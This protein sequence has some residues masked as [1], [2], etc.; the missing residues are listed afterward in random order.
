MIF[1][2]LKKKIVIAIVCA[3]IG[4]IKKKEEFHDMRL[5]LINEIFIISGGF[6]KNFTNEIEIENFRFIQM[7]IFFSYVL[8]VVQYKSPGQYHNSLVL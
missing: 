8:V 3:F 1:K 7:R 4:Y 5:L 2:I 6:R